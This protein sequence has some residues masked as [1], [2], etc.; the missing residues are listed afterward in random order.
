MRKYAAILA[1]ALLMSV[2]AIVPAGARTTT[3]AETQSQVDW[4][5]VVQEQSFD[6][7]PDARR[8]NVGWSRLVRTE[9]GLRATVSV[10][11]LEPGGVYTFWWVS[12]YEFDSEGNPVIPSGVFVARGAG[13]VIGRS[14]AA[15][16]SMQARTGQAG[17][18][19]LP[20]LGGALWHDMMDPMTSIVRV[21]IAYHG[22][23]AD[24]GN[25]LDTWLSD[26]WTGTACPENGTTNAAG[27][28]HC[29]V[30]IAATHAP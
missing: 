7:A 24:A 6:D 23:A 4:A 14:G 10:R 22:Q 20:A 17:I 27:Q 15:T 26:F 8:E 1:A 30:Y 25:D 9:D 13:T 5:P 29:P 11:G 28:P 3:D 16:I 2:I 21:E 12:P 18:T 19:G